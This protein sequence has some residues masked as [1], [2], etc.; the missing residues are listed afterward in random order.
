MSNAKRSRAAAVVPLAAG[1]KDRT[2]PMKFTSPESAPLI[3]CLKVKVVVGK[4]RL[5]EDR[6]PIWV[7]A[8]NYPAEGGLEAF[9]D[10][11]HRAPDDSFMLADAGG[12]I[13]FA[14][15]VAI[16]RPSG[17]GE[18]PVKVEPSPP[19]MPKRLYRRLRVPVGH[20]RQ[21]IV[22]VANVPWN[23]NG[24]AHFG[25]VISKHR[26]CDFI[27][28][29]YGFIPVRSVRLEDLKMPGE[30]IAPRHARLAPEDILRPEDLPE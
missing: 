26:R 8:A 24:I 19:G 6:P 11:I 10:L 21:E 5:G 27:T 28:S 22:E 2:T 30:P 23:E 3:P 4:D 16:R 25:L 18:Y 29:D 15:I 1:K 12:C 7:E 9:Y 20:G 13:A 17:D 14:S